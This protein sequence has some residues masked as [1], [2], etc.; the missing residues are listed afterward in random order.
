MYHCHIRF[1]L[2]GLRRSISNTIKHTAPLE[3]FTHEFIES[4]W[5]DPALLAQAD[6]IL[7]EFPEHAPIDAV[8]TLA[9]GKPAS[10]E[11]I[12]LA[13]QAQTAALQQIPSV[14]S[15]LW[16]LPMTGPELQ[17]RFVKWQQA[18]KMR[19]DY[20]QTSQFFEATINN[21][22]NLIWYKDK[23]GIHEKVNDS[24]CKTVGKE[25]SDVEGRGHAYIW[26]VEQDDPACIESEREVMTRRVTCVSEETVKTGDGTKLLT[27]YKSPLYDLDGSVMGTVGVAIDVTQERAYQREII[28]KNQTLETIFTTL[29]CGVMRHTLDG[30]QILSINRAA[31]NILGYDSQEALMAAGFD[32]VA[33]SVLD[34]DKPLLRSAIQSLK[35]EDDS[36][37]VEYRV[38]HPNGDILHVM[39]SVKLVKEN[40]Q[41][42]YQR[43][44]LDCTEQKL[45]EK[46]EQLEKERHQMELIQALSID[47]SLV[48]F[49]DLD[50]GTG[51]PL[52]IDEAH[53][54]ALASIFTKDMNLDERMERY[55]RQYV[56][57]EDQDMLR[58]ASS[59]NRLKRELTAN[60]LY[61]VNYRI[62]IDGE[63]KYFRMKVVRAG[64]WDESHGIVLGLCS[65]DA[66]T[67]REME[68]KSL[69]ESALQQ[70]NRANQAKSTFLSN[71]SHDIRTPMNAIIGFTGLAAKHI[72]QKDQ[73]ETYLDK[74]KTSGSHLLNLINDILDMSY[75]ESGKIQLEEA[76]CSLSELLHSLRSIV[77]VDVHAGE[78]ELHM[79]AVD[80]FDEAIYCDRL[81]L[82]QVLLNLLSNAIKY[83]KPGG[84]IH[85]CLSEQPA[86]SASFANYEFVIT[87]T[88]IGM[89]PDFV[90]RIF[91]P[92]ERERNS[93]LSGIQGT[94]LGMSIT[95]SI[96]DMMGGTITVES[97][98]GV[99]TTVTV[100]FTFRLQAHA[101]PLEPLPEWRHC[102]A[103][104]IDSD[105]G[106]NENIS[107]IL[108]KLDMNADCTASPAEA[109]ALMRQAA[110]AGQPYAAYLVDWPLP[111]HQ[112][113]DLIQNIRRESAPETPVIVLSE[114]DWSD[115]EEAATAAG[116]TAFCSKPLLLS[117]F[118]S[119]LRAISHPGDGA[120]TAG[121][122]GQEPLRSGRILLAEDNALN[123]E[124]AVA[125]LSEAG[126]QVDVADNGRIA[127]DML[128]ASDPGYYQLVLMDV[129]MPE[130]N[131]Y[132][133]ATAIR[134]LE[135][136]TLSAIPVLAMTAN[137]FE[138]DK[139]EALLHGMNGH[140]AKPID[141]DILFETLDKVL[142]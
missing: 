129:Q 5:P 44:L 11:L 106:T 121:K 8:Q 22:P 131:G 120:N 80:V 124:I 31:L 32:T 118:R 7:W 97:Q 128:Q 133:A 107:H 34:E 40:G 132:E 86:A 116:A 103:L 14:V 81:R 134:S 71:M 88:G 59:R 137:A 13:R 58:Q 9:A 27:T 45:Q 39:G 3:H 119:C 95:K 104:V 114:Q 73:V 138:E 105:G 57:L 25:K 28:K 47:Y 19:K 66:E 82:N 29:D 122:P 100:C 51:M 123:Q 90:S 127:V 54:P 142:G 68:K 17:F 53:Y 48:C 41:L 112:A 78:L 18:F 85:L 92:F 96:V 33:Q 69:L 64:L 23:H 43:F 70:A 139:R 115:L 87:D 50:T 20:W 117:E 36:V 109:L 24:F 72:D 61:N 12:I 110:Q 2:I 6:V 141:I 126:F 4:D 93:T 108:K 130:M 30:S 42:L 91:D 35:N 102:K 60:P 10:A 67:R 98:Q 26:D 56:Y 101:D 125:I 37:S 140:I 46:R 136:P 15:D 76:P 74:I 1:Y 62:L 52:Q 113:E 94:G 99:G 16:P 111:A 63:M 55:I 89:S 65:V 49:F 83:T 38:Q 77:Q 84:S 79:D 135:D 21:I 75:I